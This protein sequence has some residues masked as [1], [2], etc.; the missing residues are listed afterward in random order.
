MEQPNNRPFSNDSRLFS[1]LFT[2]QTFPSL[3]S[4][5]DSIYLLVFSA[6]RFLRI[7][8]REDNSTQSSERRLHNFQVRT[9][10]F[11]Y[12]ILKKMGN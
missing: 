10:L 11:A 12:V 1:T 9:G 3:D 4:Q 5:V 2:D 8:V 6:W 7:F